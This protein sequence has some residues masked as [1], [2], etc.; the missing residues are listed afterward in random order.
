MDTISFQ[1]ISLNVEVGKLPYLLGYTENKN[2]YGFKLCA[3]LLAGMWH[4]CEKGLACV[5]FKEKRR[6]TSNRKKC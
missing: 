5:C 4:L 1:N 2:S 6:Y 3:A